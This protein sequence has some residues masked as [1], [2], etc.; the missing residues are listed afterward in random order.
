MTAAFSL[1]QYVYKVVD[2]CSNYFLPPAGAVLARTC[3]LTLLATV[4]LTL[5]T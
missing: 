4:V 1:P 2:K 3:P 5:L